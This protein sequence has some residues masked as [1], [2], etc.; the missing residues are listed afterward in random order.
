MTHHGPTFWPQKA[1][2]RNSWN[3]NLVIKDRNY[4]IIN[5]V[6]LRLTN[7]VKFLK[8]I[9]F[10]AMFNCFFTFFTTLD[11]IWPKLCPKT[12]PSL[13]FFAGFQWNMLVDSININ[14][15]NWNP[16]VPKKFAKS[17]KNYHFLAQLVQKW[18]LRGPQPQQNIFFC[19]NN[20]PDSKLSKTFLSKCHMFWLSYECFF[21]FVW[22]FLLSVISNHNS[23]DELCEHI[24]TIWTT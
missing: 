13:V 12:T 5:F 18:S 14:N 9:S 10:F 16:L 2:I 22:C 21:Y 8:I 17:S 24:W 3:S 19:R 6:T 4:I 11:V 15:F 1:L 23:C 7:K 20:K